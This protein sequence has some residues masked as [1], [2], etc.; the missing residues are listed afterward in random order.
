MNFGVFHPDTAKAAKTV[1]PDLDI[2]SDSDIVFGK[3]G[4]SKG[5]GAAGFGPKKAP[6]SGK[7][8]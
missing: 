2:S 7:G 5:N 3:A 8:R 1:A 4:V 6:L